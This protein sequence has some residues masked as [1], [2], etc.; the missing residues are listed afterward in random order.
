MFPLYLILGIYFIALTV[1]LTV[2]AVRD[3]RAGY[4]RPTGW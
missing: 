2:K 3:V 1:F 4:I